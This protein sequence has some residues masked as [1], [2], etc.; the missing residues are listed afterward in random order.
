VTRRKRI[1][2]KAVKP[3]VER[4]DHLLFY[5]VQYEGLEQ[6]PNIVSTGAAPNQQI[7]PGVKWC[8]DHLPHIVLSRTAWKLCECLAPRVSLD[9]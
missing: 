9:A 8:F 3:V 7:I 2:R 6:S 1:R 4:R 5:P